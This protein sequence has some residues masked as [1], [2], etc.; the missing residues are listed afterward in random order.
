MNRR[1]LLAAV[2][3]V[4]LFPLSQM[5]PS[6]T[7]HAQETSYG[8]SPWNIDKLS[9]SVVKGCSAALYSLGLALRSNSLTTAHVASLQTAFSI[10]E[11]NEAEVGY[12]NLID[13]K[14][15]TGILDCRLSEDQIDQAIKS[16]T[17]LGLPGSPSS[18]KAQLLSLTDSDQS[19]LIAQ[20]S[21]KGSELI[22]RNATNELVAS[23]N[24][25]VSDKSS[26]HASSVSMK[27]FRRVVVHS[28]YCN[29]LAGGTVIA[30]LT[31][32]APAA[33]FAFVAMYISC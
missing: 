8:S 28:A 12:F 15:R 22:I 20:I 18:L 23:L 26:S 9:P 17:D 24:Q 27:Y 10:Y 4:A 2:P 11:G 25:I 19:N 3:A 33:A 5:L 1:D 29:I 21:Q 31:G 16:Y 14:A 6:E 13:T 30:I 32:N 7:L